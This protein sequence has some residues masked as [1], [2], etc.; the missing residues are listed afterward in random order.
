MS[1]LIENLSKKFGTFQALDH[2]NLEIKTGSLVALVGPSGSGKEEFGLL[3]E[4][5]LFYLFK[6]VKLVL[7]FKITLYLSI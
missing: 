2:I 7:F 3:V 5:P 1:I 6:S 4:M